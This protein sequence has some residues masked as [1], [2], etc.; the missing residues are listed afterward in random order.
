MAARRLY[1]GSLVSAKGFIPGPRIICSG[2]QLPSPGIAVPS[3]AMVLAPVQASSPPTSHTIRAAPGDGTLVSID[4]GEVKTPLPMTILTMMA[5][6]SR[7]PRFRLNVPCTL[8]SDP[9]SC[10][11]CL[12]CP[13]SPWADASSL[14]NKGLVTPSSSEFLGDVMF[15]FC[16][17]L[18][19]SSQKR[20]WEVS[21]DELGRQ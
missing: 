9:A 11:S 16:V 3:S 15:S 20:L 1:V 19:W 8:W 7:A 6:A 4:P 17:V 12:V 14:A 2:V 18:M 10:G 13:A 5:N 21:A